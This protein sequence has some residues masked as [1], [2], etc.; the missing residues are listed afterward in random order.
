[1]E[2]EMIQKSQ[3]NIKGEESWRT[4]T[5]QLQDLLSSYG[6]QGSMVAAKGQTN[7]SEERPPEI[8]PHR[9]SSLIFDISVNSIK[10]N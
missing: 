5:T 3:H 7:R 4:G 2:R 8:D 10:W 9:Y 1:M 6:K